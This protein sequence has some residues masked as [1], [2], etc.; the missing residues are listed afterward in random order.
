MRSSTMNLEAR[1]AHLLSIFPDA[2]NKSL[3]ETLGEIRAG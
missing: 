2:Q 1:K 3:R